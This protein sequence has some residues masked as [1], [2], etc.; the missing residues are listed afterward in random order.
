MKWYWLTFTDPDRAPGDRLT[1]AALVEAD[2]LGDALSRARHLG[3]D[4]SGDYASAVVPDHLVP[5]ESYCSRL[6][7][8]VEAIEV[9]AVIDRLRAKAAKAAKRR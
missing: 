3:I 9:S 7:S 1:G 2:D 4:V 6:L 5:G 8:K